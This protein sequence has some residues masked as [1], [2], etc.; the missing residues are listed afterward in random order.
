MKN[1]SRYYFHVDLDAFYA[2]VEQADNPEYRG[3][4]VIIGALPGHRGVVAACSYEARE[5]GVHSAM[6][7]SHAFRLCPG[8]VYLPV[9]MQRYQEVSCSIMNILRNYTPDMRQIS[10]DEAS[11]DMS[12]TGRLFG[13]PVSTAKKIKS[14]VKK[15]TDLTISVGIAP[16]RYLAK[17]ASEK[18]KP[19]GLYEV[20]CGDEEEFIQSLSLKDIWGLGKKMRERLAELN[21]MSPGD[22]KRFPEQMLKDMVG[23]AAGTYL[24][25]V[26]RGIDPG[27]YNENPKSRSISSEVTFEQDSRDSEGMKN[28][29]LDI[30]HQL[31]FRIMTH[32]YRAK[33]VELKIRY[34]DFTTI[35]CSRTLRHHINSAEEIYRI[36]LDLLDKRR[37]PSRAV[38][39][40]GL[41]VTSIEGDNAPMQN[42]LFEDTYDRKKRVEEAVYRI[43]KKGNTVVKAS[44]LPKDGRKAHPR[45][46]P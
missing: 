8:G 33:T 36:S 38:R 14:Q 13:P 42:E 24:Y 45:E 22:L 16:N 44:L 32:N 30:S 37:D 40:I 12:G 9:R 17:L 41:G 10:I 27:I 20:R 26:V 25:K 31:M 39:L 19:D 18:G 21:I 23:Q 34:D 1:V 29:L 35:S 15:E 7:I 43:K 4:P 46:E 11:L 5:F 2:S 28:V 3:K 6:P